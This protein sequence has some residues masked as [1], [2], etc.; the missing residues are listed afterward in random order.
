MWH[1]TNATWWSCGCDF[2][3]GYLAITPLL[4]DYYLIIDPKH[5]DPKER[6]TLDIVY[7]CEAAIYIPLSYLVLYAYVKNW[8][9]KH[10]IEAFLCG[11]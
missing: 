7:L 5:N 8:K 6:I 3:S 4:R 9:N 2:F 10:V 11:I 1:L